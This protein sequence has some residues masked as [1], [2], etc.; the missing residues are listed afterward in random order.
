MTVEPRTPAI[1]RRIVL[2]AALGSVSM[3]ALAGSQ[4]SA[5]ADG[6]RT[7]AGPPV[8]ESFRSVR[9]YPQV[10]A[11][12]RLRIPALRIDT[13]LQRLGRT[14]DQTIEVPTDFGVAGWFADGPRPG[15]SGPA[16]I[17]GHVD[18]A[19]GPGVFLRLHE[20]TPGADVLIDRADNSSVDFRV[21]SV[22]WVPKTSF[23]TELVYG[24]TLQPS[25]RLVTCGGQFDHT[26]RSYRDNVIAYADPAG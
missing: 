1:S 8:A 11:P 15:G 17:L 25:L 2:L 12:V 7:P 16:V 24:P 22:Q 10:A 4:A 5:T 23:P 26:R 19:T 3:T 21:T 14:A 9:D 18:S 6:G 13:S 20:L